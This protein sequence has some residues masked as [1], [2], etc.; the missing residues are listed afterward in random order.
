MRTEI[1]TMSGILF[2]EDE[3]G[4]CRVVT[5]NCVFEF[6]SRANALNFLWEARP[7]LLVELSKA[8][9]AHDMDATRMLPVFR[10]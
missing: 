2:A 8:K 5:P 6:T 1:N 9:Q 3:N 4:W 10:F 7:D